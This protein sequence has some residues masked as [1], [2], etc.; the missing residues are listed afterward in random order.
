M[1]FGKDGMIT[2]IKAPF[3]DF[4]RED[5]HPEDHDNRELIEKWKKEIAEYQV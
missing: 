2:S 1:L 3:K 4:Y 5:F